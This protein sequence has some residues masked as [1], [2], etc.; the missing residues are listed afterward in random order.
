MTDCAAVT[1]AHLA[2]ITG[3]EVSLNLRDKGITGL[4]AGD[5]AGLTGLFFMFLDK[6]ELTALPAGL[7]DDWRL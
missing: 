7:F 1:A 4:K 2:G 3:V 5:F 6:N